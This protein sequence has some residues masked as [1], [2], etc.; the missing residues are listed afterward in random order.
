MVVA[1]AS[2]WDIASC[3]KLLNLILQERIKIL[4]VLMVTS[5]QSARFCR[6]CSVSE[7]GEFSTG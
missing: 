5:V 3:I 4:F 1:E 6:C 2:L 7:T